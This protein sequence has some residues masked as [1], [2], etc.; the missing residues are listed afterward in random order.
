MGKFQCAKICEV[1]KGANSSNDHSLDLVAHLTSRTQVMCCFR[2]TM[3]S[4][5]T[6]LTLLSGNL[7]S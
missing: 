4:I 7:N 3:L 6:P 2:P 1:V 5:P